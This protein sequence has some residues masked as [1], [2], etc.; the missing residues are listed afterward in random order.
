MILCVCQLELYLRYL[1]EDV[2]YHLGGFL[3]ETRRWSSF[4]SAW[5][6][7]PRNTNLL[8][9]PGTFGLRKSNKASVE[10]WH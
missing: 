2:H 1:L 6:L 7:M 4:D 3:C 5:E 8:V 10:H 9:L